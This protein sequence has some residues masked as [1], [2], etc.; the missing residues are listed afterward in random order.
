ML[1]RFHHVLGVDLG[2]GKSKK[3]A[4]AT[5]RVDGATATVVDIAVDEPTYAH[6]RIDLGGPDNL[7]LNEFARQ[8]LARRT[9]SDRAGG[10][11][12]IP[13]PVLRVTG[14]LV[15]PVHPLRARQARTAVAMD[16]MPMSFDNTA[17]RNEFPGIAWQTLRDVLDDP[18]PHPA[19]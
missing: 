12:H 17:L 1:R 13:R 3:T 15:G 18:A 11:T 7:T 14:A 9:T 8:L 10:I 2:G 16:T 4:L 19:F 6:R 5:L